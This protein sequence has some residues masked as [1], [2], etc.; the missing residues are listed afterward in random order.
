[1]IF[2]ADSLTL[3]FDPAHGALVGLSAGAHSF[4]APA[5]VPR[6]LFV[7]RFRDAL[8][9]ASEVSSPEF[10]PPTFRRD[11]AV[12]HLAF[13]GLEPG[14]AVRARVQIKGAEAQWGIEVDH[15]RDGYLEWVEFP[16][17]VV[18][19][20]LIG[21]GGDGAI[22]WPAIEG[23][24]VEDLAQREQ[25]HLPYLA[26]EYPNHGWCGYYPGSA[27]MQ[28]L[29][30]QS[31]GGCLYFASHDPAHATKEIEYC[32]DAD[33]VRLIQKVYV[34]AAG[35][36]T[37]QMPYP[38][39]M[40]LL[41]GDWQDAA[42]RYRAWLEAE[43]V[44][45]AT[46]IRRRAD[47]P[48]WLADSPVVVTYPVTGV[49]HHSG[50][51]QPNEYFPFVNALPALDRL[52]ERLQSPLLVLLMHWEGTA[53]WAPPYVWPPLGGSEGLKA[54]A[55]A[56]H[57][58]G[59]RLG[60]YCSGTA[61]T[62]TADTGP[63]DY[64]RRD[65]FE[66][67]GLIKHMCQGANG[68]YEC[69]ICNGEGIRLGYDICPSTDFA[70]DVLAE[71]AVKMASVGVDY[72]QL[73]DQNLGGAAYQCHDERHGHPA[74]PGAWQAPVMRSLLG[75]V[76]TALAQA[77][78][79]QVILG[80]EA[81]SAEPYLQELPVN[82]LRF[83][84]GYNW[85]RPVPAYNTVFHE[86]GCNFMGNQ[87][88]AL[89][90]IDE[91][92]SPW[93]LCYRLAYSFAAGDLLT[94]V[95]KDRGELHWSWCTKWEVPAPAQEPHLAF[96]AHL[97]AWRRGPG[98]PYLFGGRGQASFRIEGARVVELARRSGRSL[99]VPAVL[100]SCWQAEDGRLGQF[101]V[102]FLDEPQA[103]TV[104]GLPASEVLVFMSPMGAVGSL[105]S[106]S[107]GQLSITVPPRAAILIELS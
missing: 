70:G 12:L 92:K 22:F 43:S 23:V 97:N 58:R 106:V 79:G 44:V 100:G 67:E 16:R 7:L 5:S 10:A 77:G 32:R 88:E 38:V 48:G 1:M 65:Q 102:N 101:L 27:A 25:S 42:L 52:A 6:P 91:Q 87:V 68:Q 62:N 82:D 13:A 31:G 19:N 29:A 54:F 33:G 11:G 34:G 96:M 103:V 26:I 8:G 93:N 66:R 83:H 18:P 55:D 61:W 85:G 98:K 51:T 78:A 39:V 40:A 4:I 49:G 47:L 15:D 45:D 35:R 2:S 56:L 24:L 53:P 57:E 107:R 86:Y 21:E 64:T 71:E 14:L 20:N 94:A 81:A 46:P 28:Y 41:A 30:Y 99:P 36:G 59:H 80:C 37:W 3:A 84:M 50:P 60:L 63:G 72:I 95:L 9:A 76:R 105:L 89:V 90:T 69:K 73:L 74:G 75:R 17:V 104:S